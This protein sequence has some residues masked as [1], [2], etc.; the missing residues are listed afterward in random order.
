MKRR[1]EMFTLSDNLVYNAIL[2]FSAG[3]IILGLVLVL[4][5]VL[6]KVA[7]WEAVQVAIGAGVL[8]AIII[9]IGTSFMNDQ[10]KAELVVNLNGFISGLFK[11]R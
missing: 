11:P 8:A 5:V 4:L 3:Y 2:L 1:L 7:F 9:G 6:R 10:E